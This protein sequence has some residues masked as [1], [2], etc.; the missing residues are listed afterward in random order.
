MMGLLRW[1]LRNRPTDDQPAEIRAEAERKLAEAQRQWPE[2]HR[3]ARE[4]DAL[5]AQV[6]RAMGGSR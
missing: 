1:L 2:V 6:W 5:T 4:M 3:A